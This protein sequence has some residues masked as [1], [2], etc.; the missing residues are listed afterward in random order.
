MKQ[1]AIS[2]FSLL[3]IATFLKAPAVA[4]PSL[5]TGVDYGS[6]EDEEVLAIRH[7]GDVTFA[8]RVFWDKAANE[9]TFLLAN[10]TLDKI[11][12]R[13][14][15][16]ALL[17]SVEVTPVSG[18]NQALLKLRTSDPQL[19]DDRRFRASIY[20]K[21]VL[22][23]EIFL[24]DYGKPEL[25]SGKGKPIHTQ[26]EKKFPS[27]PLNLN[28]EQEILVTTPANELLRLLS[29]RG[30]IAIPT[31][32]T[33]VNEELGQISTEQGRSAIEKIAEENL[34]NET[35]FVGNS[36]KLREIRSI[37]AL[38]DNGKEIS[39]KNRKESLEKNNK[40]EVS[41]KASFEEENAKR[42]VSSLSARIYDEDYPLEREVP[43][44]PDYTYLRNQLSDI[45]VDLN[46][47][48]GLNLYGTLMLLSQISGVSIIL[49]PYLADEP[50]GSRR[51]TKLEQPGGSGDGAPAGFR[52]AGEFAPI[53]LS[54]ATNTVIGNFNQVPFD[55]ALEIILEAH[56]LDYLVFSTP[57]SDFTKPVILVS[58]RERI[59]QEIKG[60]NKID[61][62]QLHYADPVELYN[63]LDRMDLLPS[64][65]AGWYVYTG[66]GGGIFGGGFGGGFGGARGGGIGSGAGGGRI[67]GF[68]G[69]LS[70]SIDPSS[71]HVFYLQMNSER[72]QDQISQ[73]IRLSNKRKDVEILAV[74][75]P[76]S[77]SQSV[78]YR[79]L[80]IF[81]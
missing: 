75:F 58:S 66:R 44:A 61:F 48:G 31:A 42:E 50:T 32:L 14:P 27:K 53:D 10:A 6:F 2:F 9:L 20:S 21:Y 8:D 12:V 43:L 38:L 80:V 59:E 56:D 62:Y 33:I 5:I 36:E 45:L 76:Q 35:I 16:L 49:D 11:L 68:G 26:R 67:G 23:V 4:V 37:L 70:E 81:L 29:E 3:L 39:E 22:L 54:G 41:D 55:L 73:L 63:I 71:P 60:A 57:E 34:V 69:L 30:E 1:I 72:R 64:R 52:G 18:K 65:V 77:V 40:N 51:K 7:T 74:K 78:P 24:K 17:Q 79:M 25:S 46:A 13:K 28:L 47:V 15:K 19:F